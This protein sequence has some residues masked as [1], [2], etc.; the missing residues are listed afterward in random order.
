MFPYKCKKCEIFTGIFALKFCKFRRFFPAKNRRFWFP[1]KTVDSCGSWR[2]ALVCRTKR[3]E[4]LENSDERPFFFME[5]TLKPNKNDE[6]IF[7]IF[8][9][10]LERSHYFQHFRRRWKLRG[11]TGSTH[12]K[13]KFKTLHSVSFVIRIIRGWMRY[14]WWS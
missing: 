2:R 8:T 9:L 3:R 11:K 6:K 5:I 14:L 4:N 13:L 7:C 1:P 12:Q 10:S